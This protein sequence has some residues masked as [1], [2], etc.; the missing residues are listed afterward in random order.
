M[1][2]PFIYEV[3]ECM[4]VHACMYLCIYI[5]VYVG[6]CVSVGMSVYVCAVLRADYVEGSLYICCPFVSLYIHAQP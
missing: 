2:F 5:C 1:C 3:C 4:C 6:M